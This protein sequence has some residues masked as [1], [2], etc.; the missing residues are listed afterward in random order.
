LKRSQANFIKT[1]RE[2]DAWPADPQDA[3]GLEKLVT[4]EL[5]KHYQSVRFS[6]C[7]SQVEGY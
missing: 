6:A 5:M 1:N 3:Y 7:Y 4:E 2:S